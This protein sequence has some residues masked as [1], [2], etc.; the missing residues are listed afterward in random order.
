[1]QAKADH[2]AKTIFLR[3]T[4]SW[5]VERILLNAPPP[6]NQP[7]NADG[8]GDS[9]PQILSHPCPRCGGRMIILETFERG[10]A[11]R[12]RPTALSRQRA[13]D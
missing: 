3:P 11:P 6:H 10:C 1:L 7:S 13:K 2:S 8:L 4:K 12:Y 5:K 9:E